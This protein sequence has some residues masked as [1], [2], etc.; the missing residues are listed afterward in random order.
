MLHGNWEY[1]D[2]P[3]KLFDYEKILDIFTNID[4][5]HPKG[6]SHYITCDVARGG[7]DFTVIM[8]WWGL[9][10]IQLHFNREGNNKT[11]RLKLEHLAGQFNIPRSNIVIDE[12]GIGGGL[13]DEMQGVKGFVNNSRAFEKPVKPNQLIRHNFANLKSQCYFLL[14]E[15]V[16]AGKVGVQPVVPEVKKMMIEDLEQIKRKDF[17]KDGKLQVI[18]KDVIKENIGRST[19][20]GDA[21]MMR[22]LWEVRPSY[23]PYIAV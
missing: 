1:D 16:N 18:G 6:H 11:L 21:L 12:D 13:V 22:M 7:R 3:S 20:F 23:R 8:I 2:D 9:E 5:P 19:D 17:D 15:Y 4:R 10:V 14:A